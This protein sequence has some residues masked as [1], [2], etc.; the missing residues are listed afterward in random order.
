[1]ERVKGSGIK[2]WELT[3]ELWERVK[4]FVPQRKRAGNKT[5]K[6]KPGAGR[7]PLAPR[8]VL[9]GIFY[10]LRTGIQWKA[11]PVTYGAASSIHSYFSE[12]AEAGFFRRMWEEG[13]IVYDLVKGLGWEWQSVDGCMVKAPLAREAVGNNPTDRGK[14]RDETEPGGRKTRITHRYRAGW[15]EPA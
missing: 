9:E 3:D 10:V 14:K 15:G 11:L 12:W 5:Y 7:K 1:M 13:L 6:R 2:S 4:D 8:Q